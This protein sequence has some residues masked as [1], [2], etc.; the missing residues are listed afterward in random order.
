MFK[1]KNPQIM[2]KLIVLLTLTILLFIGCERNYS[3]AIP[4]LKPTTGT[5]RFLGL[6]DKYAVRLK[7]NREY[8]YACAATKG[9]WRLNILEESSTWEYLG[10]ADTSM[11]TYSDRGLQDIIFHDENPGW[12][13]VT[14]SIENPS[15]HALYRSFNNGKIW[16]PA[17]SSLYVSSSYGDYWY[18]KRIKKFTKAKDGILGISSGVYLSNDFA[19]SW[20]KLGGIGSPAVDIN[21]V[22][23]HQRDKNVIWVGGESLYFEPVVSFSKDTGNSWTTIDLVGT[24]PTDN[25]VYSIAID[26]NNSDIV[27]LCMQGAIIKTKDS[28]KSWIVPLTTH[29]QG[30]FFSAILS[31]PTSSYRIYAT[32]GF[33]IFETLDA[34]NS[35]QKI[36]HSL[37]DMT[38]IYR[39]IWG[40]DNKTIY[41]GTTKGV[42][43]FKIN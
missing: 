33:D 25:A 36:E 5:W 30:A 39:M 1:N 23:V 13:L 37:P 15:E 43:E 18:Y 14:L 2:I 24:V 26:P 21:E 20:H 41:F 35:W 31:H 22:I 27:Y 4:Y 10:L 29:P 8:L 3:P 6:E 11:G 40:Y 17:D 7:L 9:L 12:L 34:G 19:K 28:G 42:Y 16:I 32:A 38:V